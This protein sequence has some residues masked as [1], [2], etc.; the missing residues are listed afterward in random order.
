MIWYLTQLKTLFFFFFQSASNVQPSASTET[1]STCCHLRASHLFLREPHLQVLPAT[2]SSGFPLRMLA[3]SRWCLKPPD[4][5]TKSQKILSLQQ[6]RPSQIT[7]AA[8]QRLL[9]S[10]LPLTCSHK[11]KQVPARWGRVPCSPQ[12]SPMASTSRLISP[13]AQAPSQKAHG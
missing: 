11:H 1:L 13:A 3:S 12:S 5:R 7:E 4:K 6:S 10:R 2:N 8:P 9:Y